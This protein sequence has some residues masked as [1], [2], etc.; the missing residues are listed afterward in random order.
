M[1]AQTDLEKA[2]AAADAVKAA[3][4]NPNDPNAAAKL[5]DALGNVAD[6]A[7]KNATATAA[8]PVDPNAPDPNAVGGWTYDYKQNGADWPKLKSS[9]N[10]INYCGQ[11]RNQSPI[12]LLNP[13]GSYGWAYGETIPKDSDKFGKTYKDLRKGTKVGWKDKAMAVELAEIETLENFFESKIG[14]DYLR[15][16]TD[17]YSVSEFYLR[18]PSEHTVMGKHLDIELQIKHKAEKFNSTANIK[19][20]YVSIFFSVEEYDRT[21]TDAQNNTIQNFFD[22]L[23]FKNHSQPTV[24]NIGYGKLMEIIDHED[25]WIYK[26]SET[27]PPCEQFVYWNVVKRVLPIR[28]AEFARFKA[29]METR[30]DKLGGVTHNNRA[31]QPINDHGIR[32]TSATTF[33]I[34]SVLS[35]LTSLLAYN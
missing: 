29:L 10:A 11:T 24:D 2:K 7:L 12:N 6:A 4:K 33:Q 18:S 27:F 34:A 15:A 31:I 35:V 8:K 28:I 5:K 30:K 26:G 19:Y 9:N 21:V 1:S 14:A 23:D 20:A 13:I 22:H 16:A 32:Y 3:L 17:K 25:R